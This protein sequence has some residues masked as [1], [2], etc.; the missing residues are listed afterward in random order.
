MFV[1]NINDILKN[2]DNELAYVETNQIDFGI[3]YYKYYRNIKTS[4]S[5]NDINNLEQR[6]SDYLKKLLQELVQ[7]LPLNINHFKGIQA[8][9]PGVCLSRT[10]KLKFSDLPL[11]D[12]FIDKK[13]LFKAES[14][15]NSLTDVD[16]NLL[17]GN[18]MLIDSYRF[19]PIVAQYK[20]SG[21]FLAFNTIAEFALKF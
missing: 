16:W 5:K 1:Q 9:S 21:G 18:D 11:I 8:L 7:R 20:N 6:A 14:E 10:A 15:Y 12:T 4:L 13:D 2:I 19:S 17:Y 3:E